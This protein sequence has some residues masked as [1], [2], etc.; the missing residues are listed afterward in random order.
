[1]LPQILALDIW[2]TICDYLPLSKIQYFSLPNKLLYNHIS[3]CCPKLP[4]DKNIHYADI[5]PQVVNLTT[6]I[7]LITVI[8]DSANE[9]QKIKGIFIIFT[10]KNVNEKTFTV[11]QLIHSNIIKREK[12]LYKIRLRTP[13]DIKKCLCIVEKEKKI[14]KYYSTIYET[15]N[16]KILIHKCFPYF[17]IE[18]N[19]IL[20]ETD[21]IQ[22]F[23]NVY[24]SMGRVKSFFRNDW[25]EFSVVRV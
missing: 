4:Y 3:K 22:I 20:S 6:N 7:I 23:D 25:F 2:Y 8:T 24:I 1:M 15:N 19:F 9:K 21:I 17:Y 12:T 16:F 11:Q 5:V 10:K 14:S 13:Y 18:D